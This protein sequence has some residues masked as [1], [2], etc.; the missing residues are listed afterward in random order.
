MVQSYTLDDFAA[1]EAFLSQDILNPMK[2]ATY[3]D[4]SR[5]GQLIVVSR[6]LKTAHYATG[7][8]DRLQQA[9]D[10]WN[11]ISPQLQDLYVAL[12]QGRAPHA[13]PFDPARCQAPL[14][15]VFQRMSV[16]AYP[17]HLQLMDV[18]G[19]QWRQ[20][21]GDDLMGAQEDILV[22]DVAWGIDF[23]AGWA[24][25]T[26][27]VPM[28]ST[29]DQVLEAVRLLM[30]CNEW[31]A[32]TPASALEACVQAEYGAAFSP[33]AVTPDELG[34]A[35]SQ[36]RLSLTLH[37][38]VNGRKVGM[39]DAGEMALHV[40]QLIAAAT[41]SR[42]M[43]AGALVCI[44]PVANAALEIKGALEWPKGYGSI[45]QKRAM[46]AQSADQALTPYLQYGDTVR[47]EMNARDGSRLFGA[48][49]QTVT[50]PARIWVQGRAGP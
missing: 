44:G 48:I 26:G 46:E 16:Q 23:A 15:R 2:L 35:W 19:P 17:A 24:C 21:S 12:N 27:D 6:D 11:F 50:P 10:D 31:E 36:G 3:K 13:F 9:L 43:R 38:S 45:A 37:C 4:G 5:D 33:V 22:P 28:G 8:A 47:I 40:G 41:S 39:C 18:K 29:P 30:L 49:S 25:V 20:A 14:P 34:D 7:I 42:A 32:R 1:I